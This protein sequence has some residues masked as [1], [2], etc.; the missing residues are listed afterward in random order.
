[1]DLAN[2]H[3]VPCK[4]GEGALSDEDIAALMAALP[5]WEKRQ[6]H[7]FRRMICKN[8]VAALALVNHLAEIAETEQHHPDITFGWGYVE[9]TLTT[10]SIGDVSRNDFILAAK[11]NKWLE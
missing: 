9:I 4:K 1:M 6:N 5:A 11:M 2:E 8:F 10:H 7:L 3:C